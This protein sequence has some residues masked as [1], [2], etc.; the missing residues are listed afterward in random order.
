[1]KLVNAPVIILSGTLWL[2]SCCIHRVQ[3]LYI[4]KGKLQKTFSPWTLHWLFVQ[5]IGGLGVACLHI[6]C[7]LC[8]KLGRFTTRA[9]VLCFIRNAFKATQARQSRIT[10]IPFNFLRTLKCGPRFVS[11]FFCKILMNSFHSS[12]KTSASFLKLLGRFCCTTAGNWV[13]QPS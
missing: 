9:R 4:Q 6:L 8:W 1:M 10:S 7:L 5:S 13:W 2:C 3:P 12:L 11:L